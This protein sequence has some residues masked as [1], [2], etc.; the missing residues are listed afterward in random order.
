M[1]KKRDPNAAEKLARIVAEHGPYKRD[2]VAAATKQLKLAPASVNSG[3]GRLLKQGRISNPERG[4]YYPATAGE[5]RTPA[6]PAADDTIL[7]PQS[8][9][10][11]LTTLAQ[12]HA[13]LYETLASIRDQINEVI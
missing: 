9:I 8:A 2:I 13:V 10:E 11:Q 6:Q 12:H 4:K 3:L 1:A 7:D 5:P